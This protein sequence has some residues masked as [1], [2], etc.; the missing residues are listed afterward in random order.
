MTLALCGRP[1]LEYRDGPGPPSA[2]SV[3]WAPGGSRLGV[4][5]RR[6]A[7]AVFALAHPAALR[8]LDDPAYFNSCT[9]KS[10]AW[11]GPRGDLLLT[12]SDDF[13]LFAWRV[14]EVPAPAA[15][16]PHAASADAVFKGH[17]SIVNQVRYSQRH[18]IIVSSGV[19]KIIKVCPNMKLTRLGA[20]MA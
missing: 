5:R 4:I 18:Q 10:L 13:S 12:G 3:A 17:R 2:M 16:G 1:V 11:G 15:P 20:S 9:M 8:R 19:E 6:G 14:P 7:P